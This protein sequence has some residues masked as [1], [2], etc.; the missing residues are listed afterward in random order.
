MD[1]YWPTQGVVLELDGAAYH[2]DPVARRLD[3][4]KVRDL[5][6][7]GLRVIRVSYR[8]MRDHPERV[9]ARVEA[10]LAELAS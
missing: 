5:E 3:A 2:S 10:I 4:K 6:A 8:E 7:R 1:F 9:I